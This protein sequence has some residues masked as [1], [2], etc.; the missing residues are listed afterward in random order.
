MANL[1][2]DFASIIIA[3]SISLASHYLT[4]KG[5]ARAVSSSYT[6]LQIGTEKTFH[7]ID[8]IS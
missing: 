1:S 7:S 6:I 4:T 8:H 3:A 5:T 2:A